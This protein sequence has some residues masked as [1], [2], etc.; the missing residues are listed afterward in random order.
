MRTIA[1]LL[2]LFIFA[3][4]T[5]PLYIP[6]EKNVNKVQTASLAELQQG[7][8]LYK[9]NCGNCHKIS[10]PAD[11]SADQWTK[12]LEK[13]GPKAKLSTEKVD[14]VYKYLVNH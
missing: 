2:V 9:S 12:I 1:A 6:A 3:A 10:K 11:H 5:T 13:M 4:C 7:Y 8:E 14:L